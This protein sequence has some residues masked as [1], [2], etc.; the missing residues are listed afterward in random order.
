[1]IDD[2][3]EKSARIDFNTESQKEVSFNRNQGYSESFNSFKNPNLE[4]IRSM[5]AQGLS[6]AE[7]SKALNMGQGEIKLILELGKAR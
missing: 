1:M 5:R 6:I 3:K 7:I 4:K 2:M